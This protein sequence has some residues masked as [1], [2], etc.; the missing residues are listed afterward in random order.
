MA[1]VDNLIARKAAIAA[2]LAVGPSKPSYTLNGQNVQWT[3]YRKSL[4]DELVQ[5]NILINQ[6]QPWLIRTQAL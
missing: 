6:E 4:L 5:L 2:E 3:E 1:V